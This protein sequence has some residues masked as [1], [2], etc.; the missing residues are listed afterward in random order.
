MKV[1]LTITEEIE[2]GNRAAAIGKPAAKLGHT[3]LTEASQQPIDPKL[4]LEKLLQ[5]ISSL[6]SGEE[7]TVRGLA[8][9][10]FSGRQWTY[11]QT[12]SGPKPDTTLGTV[13]RMLRTDSRMHSGAY[14]VHHINEQGVTVFAKI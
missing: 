13:G 8:K 10:S 9:K 14:Q 5:E 6:D 7:F 4:V 3:I 2:F 1:P 11:V 12:S